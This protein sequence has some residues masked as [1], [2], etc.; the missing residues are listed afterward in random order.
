MPFNIH[1]SPLRW[2]EVFG[3][4][5]PVSTHFIR[6]GPRQHAGEP[7][8]FVVLWRWSEAPLMHM[9]GLAPATSHQVNADPFLEAAHSFAHAYGAGGIVVTNLFCCRTRYLFGIQRWREILEF[10]HP[11]ETS[12][13]DRS[14]YYW[15]KMCG[16]VIYAFQLDP[17]MPYELRLRIHHEQLFMRR[18]TAPMGL[19]VLCLGTDDNG[20][21]VY[22]H[23]P[24]AS[25]PQTW[26]PPKEMPS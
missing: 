5:A 11:H 9:C 3:V 24:R 14:F 4:D 16:H 25:G 23:D 8:R 15:T 20:W 7:W 6:Y 2:K 12:L 21:P 18:I 19:P 26:H 13:K 17:D 22:P 1:V 10:H